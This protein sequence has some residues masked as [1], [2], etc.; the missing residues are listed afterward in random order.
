MAFGSNDIE[1]KVKVDAQGAVSVFNQMGEK[2]AEVESAVKKGES[3]WTT[4]NQ[5]L[6][7]IKQTIGLV[8]GALES[9]FEALQRGSAVSDVDESFRNLSESAGTLSSVFLKQLNEATG[10]TIANF[11]LQKKAIEAVRTGAS[12]EEFITLTKAARVLSEQTGGDLKESLDTVSKAFETGRTKALQN[13]L[14]VIDL[15]KAELELANALGIEA[16]ELSAEQKLHA[17]RKALLEASTKATENFGAITN[18]TGDNISRMS[19]LLTDA[20]DKFLQAISDSEGLT[21]SL[22]ELGDVIKNFDWDTFATAATFTANALKIAFKDIKDVIDYLRGA[23]ATGS[24]FSTQNLAIGRQIAETEKQFRDLKEGVVDSMGSISAAIKKAATEQ[25]IE[26]VR[27]AIFLLNK[28]VQQSNV[29]GFG[30]DFEALRNQFEKAVDNFTKTGKSLDQVKKEEKEAALAA[31]K[32]AEEQA[33]AAEKA[34]KLKEKLDSVVNEIDKAVGFDRFPKLTEQIQ[35]AFER[36]SVLG[37]E[38]VANALRDIAIQA[39]NAGIPLD[40]TANKIKEL[41]E[42]TKKLKE[43]PPVLTPE[44]EI[45]RFNESVDKAIGDTSGGFMDILQ[46]TASNAL[47]QGLS[48]GVDAFFSGKTLKGKDYGAIVGGLAGGF[49][50]AIAPGSG[51]IVDSI[52]QGLFT[53]FNQDSASTKARKEADKFF[54]DAFDANRLSIIVGDSVAKI[55]DLVFQGNTLFGGDVGFNDGAAF[56]FLQSLPEQARRAFI[57]VGAAFDELTGQA[58]ENG[59]QLAAVFANNIGGSLNNLQLLVEAT[60]KSFDDLKKSVVESFLDGKISALEAQTA[61]IGIQQ[62]S[63]KGIPGAIGAVTE[64]FNNLKAAGVKGGRALID[65]L[66]DI[67]FEARELGIKDLAGVQ[68]NLAATGQFS[69]EE[70]QKVF[71]ALKANGIDSIEELT[72]ATA[73]QLIPVLSQLQASVFPFAEAAEKVGDLAEKLNSLPERIDTTVHV[74]FVAT[75]DQAARNIIGQQAGIAL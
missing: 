38:G 33:K 56:G 42:L 30:K 73:E 2:I 55:S 47:Y 61:L 19:K 54:A 20:K 9:T 40:V 45:A 59:G 27:S 32:L 72:G 14:G 50:D 1:I 67:G 21:K 31:G 34:A 63:E 23:A 64:A 48:M 11:D 10:E 8:S 6:G 52:I 69:A 24:A 66:Q 36:E 15:K 4:Y 75:G 37:A 49:A 62:V 17:A 26:K 44:E 28:T 39:A 57:G 25:D 60:G 22:K 41:T 58:Q 74:N 65:A 13:S 16:K 18:D 5:A 29:K 70:I 43:L 51:Q 35:S 7:A 53:K 12:P 68:A 71:D 46:D 3:A